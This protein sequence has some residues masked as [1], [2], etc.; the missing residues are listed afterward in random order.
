MK[1]IGV[2]QGDITT[3][4]VDA[5]V[6]AANG[7]LA[8]G[9]GVDGAIHRAAGKDRL[10]AACAR[11]GPCPTG[12]VRVTPGFDLAARGIIHAVG[13]VWQG[14]GEGEDRLLASCYRNALQAAVNYGF[15]TIAFPAISC[16]VYC[17]PPQRAV[18]VA[19]RTVQ[20]E[21]VKRPQIK[22][23]IFCCFDDNMANLYRAELAEQSC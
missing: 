14:G 13:P 9:G 11:L 7:R 5:V 2:F 6:N 1:G 19:V 23:V 20:A 16:G 4:N 17:F 18:P 22:Q 10:R 3:L 8:G 15:K 12:E 21:L